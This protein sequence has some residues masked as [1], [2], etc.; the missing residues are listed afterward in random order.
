MTGPPPTPPASGRGDSWRGALAVRLR[1]IVRAQ[2]RLVALLVDKLPNPF[3]PPI[4][5]VV[6][7]RR[8]LH[9]DEIIL[10]LVIGHRADTA[11]RVL[12]EFERDR[13]LLEQQL[14][15]RL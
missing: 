3:L 1:Q 6:E 2:P 10:G 13:V 11:H 7:V 15:D 14:G 4:S 12:G 9:A 5:L 8:F